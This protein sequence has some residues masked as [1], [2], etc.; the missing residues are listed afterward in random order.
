MVVMEY[1]IRRYVL[2]S[3]QSLEN[4]ICFVTIT[5]ELAFHIYIGV[6]QATMLH[7]HV[8]AVAQNRQT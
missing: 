5:L 4:K 2:I 3:V 8:S 6:G 1:N 7:S